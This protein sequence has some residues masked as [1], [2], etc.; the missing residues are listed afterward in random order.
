M[1]K[2][3]TQKIIA[4]LICA[5]FGAWSTHEARAEEPLQLKVLCYNIHYGQGMDKEYNIPRLAKVIS[6]QKPD[7][8]ALQEVDVHVKRSGQVHQAQKLAELTGMKVRFGPTQHYEGGL[9]GNAV[10]TNLPIEDVHIQPLPYSES[11]PEK[12]TYPRA[13]IAVKLLLPNG[14]RLK[15]ISTHFQHN[16]EEDRVQEATAINRFFPTDDLPTILAGDMNATPEAEPVKILRKQWQLAIDEAN[17]PS[18]PS[19]KPSSR[20]DYIFYRGPSLKLI[21]SEVI[22]EEM[23]SDHRPVLAIFE[24]TD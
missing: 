20:I 8:V 3:F 22:A 10:L 15:V 24:M 18:A 2:F 23:A 13:A 16:M 1:S 6:D 12:T 11:T 21:H 19:I 7:I 9:F 4:G 14:K 17:S 5:L